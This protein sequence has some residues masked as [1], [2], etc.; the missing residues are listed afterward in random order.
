[1]EPTYPVEKLKEKRAYQTYDNQLGKKVQDEVRKD[2]RSV[3]HLVQNQQPY[4]LD[5]T[6]AQREQDNK[7]GAFR[8]Y[9]Q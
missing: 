9:L 4:P 1:M 6:T 3:D 5:K 2:I 7:G 8:I